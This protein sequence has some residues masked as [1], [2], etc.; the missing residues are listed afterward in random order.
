MARGWR[1]AGRARLCYIILEAGSG[2]RGDIVARLLEADLARLGLRARRVEEPGDECD[3]LLVVLASGGTEGEALGI[4]RSTWPVAV[5]GLPVANSASS[6]A[7]IRGELG[8]LGA[9]ALTLGP[10]GVGDQST[11]AGL[12]AVVRG[13]RAAWATR[14]SRLGLI[15]DPPSWIVEPGTGLAERLGVEVTRVRVEELLERAPRDPPEPP[16]A[17]TRGA[18]HVKA[19][20]EALRDALR[21]YAALKRLAG[22]L[23]LDSLAPSCPSFME[24]LGSNACLA[25]ALLNMEGLTVGCEGDVAATLSLHVLQSTALKPGFLAN[26][27]WV[28]GRRLGLAH[29]G[30]SPSLGLAHGV[31]GHFITGRSPTLS[32]WIPE[33]VPATVLQASPDGGGAVVAEAHIASGAPWRGLQCETQVEVELA[34]PPAGSGLGLGNHVALV[35]GR[36]GL[37][38]ALAWRVLNPRG[39]LRLIGGV[40]P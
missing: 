31:E 22:E 36:H 11:L 32:L 30:A 37:A 3:G 21:V 17:L 40:P 35:M 7:S 20:R 5:L 10:L 34:E 39:G 9:A 14:G 13:L 8:E 27:A 6:L 29:C 23:G 38:A 25:H 16:P 28:R 26:T 15:G 1:R 24:E 4:A 19:T 18:I 2:R 33:G 12:E